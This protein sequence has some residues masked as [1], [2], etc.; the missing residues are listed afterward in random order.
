MSFQAAIDW[1]WLQLPN[2]TAQRFAAYGQP[3]FT[4]PDAQA[5]CPGGPCWIWDPLRFDVD[6]AN[7]SV[8]LSWGW[9]GVGWITCSLLGWL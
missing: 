9:V 3:L 1:A 5:V 7:S 4:A 2:A 8:R 6:D